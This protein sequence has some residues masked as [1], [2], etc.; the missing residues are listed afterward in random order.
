MSNKMTTQKIEGLKVNTFQ[1]EESEINR[2]FKNRIGIDKIKIESL[3]SVDARGFTLILE[4][5]MH[6]LLNSSSM[7]ELYR[8]AYNMGY[9]IPIWDFYPKDYIQND[10]HQF[11][12]YFKPLEEI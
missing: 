6:Y 12:V 4:C 5:N 11:W 3:E 8:V 1:Y 2:I 9:N 10:K 7:E